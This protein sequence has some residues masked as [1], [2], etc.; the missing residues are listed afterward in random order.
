MRLPRGWKRLKTIGDVEPVQILVH[1]ESGKFGTSLDGG[2]TIR[3]WDSLAEAESWVKAIN[4]ADAV[5][6]VLAENPFADEVLKLVPVRVRKVGR[7]WT[8]MDGTMIGLHVRLY[9]PDA[10]AAAQIEELRKVHS[11]ARETARQAREAAWEVVRSMKVLE[12]EH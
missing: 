12:T 4:E 1:S 8:R 5:D 3:E 7:F 11:A 6:A 2:I 9:V 10:A